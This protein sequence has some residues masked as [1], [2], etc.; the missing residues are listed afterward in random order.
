MSPKDGMLHS[1]QWRDLCCALRERTVLL[2]EGYLVQS[3]YFRKFHFQSP[4]GTEFLETF[5]G[6]NFV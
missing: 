3:Q 1:L 2:C 6:I 4:A 5:V